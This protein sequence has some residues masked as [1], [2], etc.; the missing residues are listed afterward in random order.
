MRFNLALLALASSSSGGVVAAA[1]DLR[2]VRRHCRTAGGLTLPATGSS[3]WV[4]LCPGYLCVHFAG[5]EGLLCLA[6]RSLCAAFR[7]RRA[8]CFVHGPHARL[9][10]VFVALC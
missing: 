9:G 5:A 8:V 1:S 4:L 7:F 10:S 6:L 2:H 3:P